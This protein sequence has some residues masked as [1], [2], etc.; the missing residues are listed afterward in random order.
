MRDGLYVALA[1]RPNC[2]RLFGIFM[3]VLLLLDSCCH[4][5]QAYIKEPKRLQYSRYAIYVFLAHVVD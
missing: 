2:P 3:F 5:Q 4:V 1:L